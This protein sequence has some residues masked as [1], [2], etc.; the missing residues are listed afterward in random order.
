MNKKYLNI[1]IGIIVIATV[2]VF[3]AWLLNPERKVKEEI[4]EMTAENEAAIANATEA[5]KA[6]VD[7]ANKLSGIT[8]GAV[9]NFEVVDADGRSTNFGIVRYVDEVKGESI[10]EEHMVVFN[11][12][13][14]THYSEV[15]RDTHMV[16]AMHREPQYS[17]YQASQE[18]LENIARQFLKK[19]GSNPDQY[20]S[21]LNFSANH[22]A[23]SENKWGNWFFRWD[24]KGFA[25]PNDVAMDL[26][27]FIQVGITASGFI[28]SYDNTVQLYYNLSKEALQNLCGFVEMPRTDDS[29]LN[30]EKGIVKVWFTEYEPFQNRYFILPYEPETD[31][32]GCSDSAKEFLRHLP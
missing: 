10:A 23:S 29:L 32:E 16:V 24:D 2:A 20:G 17:P 11:Q 19:I 12:I 9:F 27:P 31:F 5:L 25:L 4:Q 30:R 7:T 13:G 8:S 22:K 3:S 28:F 1:I 26:P 15:D 18:E 6:V 14:T 21:V